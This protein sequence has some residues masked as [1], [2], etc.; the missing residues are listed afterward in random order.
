MVNKQKHCLAGLSN[1][2]VQVQDDTTDSVITSLF[3]SCKKSIQL[4]LQ[5]S[6]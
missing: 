4:R 2:S 1:L 6:I 5:I 3:L